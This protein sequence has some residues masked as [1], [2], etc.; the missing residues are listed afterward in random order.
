MI[1]YRIEREEV[2]AEALIL[3]ESI[4]LYTSFEEF[5]YGKPEGYYLVPRRC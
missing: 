3:A 1:Y 2:R 5:R 4:M